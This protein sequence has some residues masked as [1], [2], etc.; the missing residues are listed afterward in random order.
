MS[1]ILKID[2]Y[3]LSALLFVLYCC[4]CQ[5]KEQVSFKNSLQ[6]FREDS[7]LI[8]KDAY[9]FFSNFKSR[10]EYL[11]KQQPR[12]AAIKTNDWLNL[13]PEKGQN[14][15]QFTKLAPPLQAADSILCLYTIGRF[16]TQQQHIVDQLSNYLNLFYKVD[17]QQIGNIA[18]DSL[19]NN[20]KRWMDGDI[21]LNSSLLINTYLSRKHHINRFATLAI[22]TANLYP[23][24]KLSY[25]FGQATSKHRIAII[26]LHRLGSTRFP[27]S[28]KLYQTRAN[29]IASHELGHALG[30]AH[31]IAF[32]CNMNGSNHLK[33]LDHQPQNFCPDCL[34][35]LYW[36]MGW[37]TN[38]SLN[39]K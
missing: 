29:K 27:K 38:N 19:P 39:M 30:L 22:S 23:S 14:F 1:A 17:I 16:D 36:T 35:K 7:T 2:W 4:S 6:V 26:S 24:Q 18:I 31:C 3:K 37:K 12:L 8:T 13:H 10:Y 15:F 5:E 21:Q 32:S 11:A 33:E 20:M 28:K 34:V 9:T 25:V